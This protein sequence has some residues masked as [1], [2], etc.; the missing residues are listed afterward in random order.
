M[1]VSAVPLLMVA[2]VDREL[3]HGSILTK[4]SNLRGHTSVMS[5]KFIDLV[6]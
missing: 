6:F 3:A 5:H 4:D 2:K 1:L